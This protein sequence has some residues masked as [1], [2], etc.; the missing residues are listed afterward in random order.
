MKPETIIGT[1]YLFRLRDDGSVEKRDL[2]IIGKNAS[3]YVTRDPAMLNK[4]NSYALADV[5]VYKSHRVI[6]EED[7]ITEA[8][9]IMCKAL[10]KKMLHL[11]DKYNK[12]MDIYTKFREVNK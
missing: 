11:Q 5:G 12:A 4:K 1:L 9:G 6:L 10:F 2:N 3:Y 8:K 7:D